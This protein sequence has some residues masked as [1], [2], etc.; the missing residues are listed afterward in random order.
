MSLA[1]ITY[2]RN[3]CYVSIIF[4]MVHVIFGCENCMGIRIVLLPD[5]TLQAPL[6]FEGVWS[7][8]YLLWQQHQTT[9]A[10]HPKSILAQV[11]WVY[12]F[13]CLLKLLSNHVSSLLCLSAHFRAYIANV[14]SVASFS[15]PW[16]GWTAIA[17]TEQNTRQKW[18]RDL[19]METWWRGSLICPRPRWGMYA[20][21]SRY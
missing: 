4:H 3:I 21:E 9:F 18:L 1:T 15:L 13:V 20:K 6:A 8:T 14:V 7:M 2:W 12:N 5:E 19:L 11:L 17:H 10:I 16:P